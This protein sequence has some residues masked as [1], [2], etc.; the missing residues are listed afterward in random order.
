VTATALRAG[1]PLSSCAQNRS[2]ITRAPGF[3]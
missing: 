3:S 2:V 1:G